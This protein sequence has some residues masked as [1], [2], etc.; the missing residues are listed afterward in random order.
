MIVSD[1]IQPTTPSSYVVHSVWPRTEADAA[2][3]QRLEAALEL[4]AWQTGV[5]GVRD[6]LLMVERT[7]EPALLRALDRAGMMHHLHIDNVTQ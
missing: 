1:F 2:L 5:P 4:D 6:A 7:H 3:L